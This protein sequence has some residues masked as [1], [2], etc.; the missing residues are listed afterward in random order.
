MIILFPVGLGARC[1]F[2]LAFVWKFNK[3][4]PEVAD[5]PLQL[6]DPLTKTQSH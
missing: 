5:P 3:N 4:V 1:L 6:L 2:L